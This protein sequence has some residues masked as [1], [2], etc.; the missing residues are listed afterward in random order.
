MHL[1]LKLTLNSS[2]EGK[3]YLE[4]PDR[5]CWQLYEPTPDTDLYKYKQISEIEQNRYFEFKIVQSLK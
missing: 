1:S 4:Q 3:E 2:Y 5:K